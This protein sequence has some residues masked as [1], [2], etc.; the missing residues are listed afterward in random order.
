MSIGEKCEKIVENVTKI[1][2]KSLIVS[3]TLYTLGVFQMKNTELVTKK[4]L[5][6][7]LFF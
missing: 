7:V 3:K 2:S 5:N 6:F 1:S 4:N